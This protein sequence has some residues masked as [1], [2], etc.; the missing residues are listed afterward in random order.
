[1]IVA[2]VLLAGAMVWVNRIERSGPHVATVL[3]TPPALPAV[4]L[5][6]QS[7]HPY[8]TGDLEGRFSL[9]FFGF[10]H[11]PDV[12][13]IT[14]QVLAET[15][16]ALA[17]T[18]APQVLF[19]SVDPRRDTP[20]RIAAYLASFDPAFRGVTAELE[21]LDPL[22]KQLGVL[23]Q[24]HGSGDGTYTVTHNS[25]VY[26]IGPRAELLAVFSGPHEAQAIADDYRRIR[27]Q[28]LRRTA[29]DAPAA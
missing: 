16:A 5:I 19:V 22:L 28:Y 7:G 4:A 14:L 29:S 9:M 2:L 23:V 3:P 26:L 15:R 10:T 11:C 12:C 18:E 8:A 20:E 25:T 13:P 21:A 27:Q 24:T 6:D 1:L 17:E